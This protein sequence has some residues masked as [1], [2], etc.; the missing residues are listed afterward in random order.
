M[1]FRESL[2]GEAL[3]LVDVT[4]RRFDKRGDGTCRCML[5][6]RGRTKFALAH[7]PFGRTLGMALREDFEHQ[8]F[9]AFDLAAHLRSLYVEAA[10]VQDERPKVQSCGS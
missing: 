4:V 5:Y 7:A 10:S 2:D 1:Q 6:V 3:M 8:D 9:V